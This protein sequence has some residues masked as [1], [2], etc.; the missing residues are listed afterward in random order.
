MYF[1][2]DKIDDSLQAHTDYI[3]GVIAELYK[4]TG[5]KPDDTNKNFS[6]GYKRYVDNFNKAVKLVGISNDIKGKLYPL[7]NPNE[8]IHATHEHFM[9][10]GKASTDFLEQFGL[11]Q[12]KKP[13]AAKGAINED[14]R[15]LGE[16]DMLDSKTSIQ[17][18]ED[19]VEVI[20]RK[21]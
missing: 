18:N 10:E 7:P 11:K 20:T 4:I 8:L 13:I 14:I 3:H 17:P 6:R 9:L 1:K 15:A 19:G 16:I 12:L 5:V 2:L 21:K